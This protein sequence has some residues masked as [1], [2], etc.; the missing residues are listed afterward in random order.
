M[1]QMFTVFI[2][3]TNVARFFPGSTTGKTTES[4]KNT[5]KESAGTV[6]KMVFTEYMFLTKRILYF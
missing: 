1:K 4:V 3:F 6:W 2:F 5:D